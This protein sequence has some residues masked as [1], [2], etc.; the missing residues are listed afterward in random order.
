MPRTANKL[1]DDL[2]RQFD[3]T[4]QTVRLWR[5]KGFPLNRPLELAERIARTTNSDSL[6]ARAVDIIKRARFRIEP[7]QSW[8]VNYWQKVC[9]NTRS[10]AVALRESVL[11][12][13]HDH[14]IRSDRPVRDEDEAHFEEL[15]LR[16]ERGERVYPKPRP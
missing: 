10:S 13:G 7:D 16:K 15:R 6:R 9:G 5:R 14:L 8:Y 4:P 11:Q 12:N 1:I 2:S 3:V